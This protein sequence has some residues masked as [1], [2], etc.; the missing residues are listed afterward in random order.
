MALGLV[1]HWSIAS[2][3]SAKIART[4]VSGRVYGPSWDSWLAADSA[5]RRFGRLSMANVTQIS[6]VDGYQR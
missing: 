5:P 2:G 3:T 1:A 4:V 6:I